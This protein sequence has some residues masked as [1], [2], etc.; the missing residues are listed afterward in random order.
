MTVSRHAHDSRSAVRSKLCKKPSAPKR[1]RR[2]CRASDAPDSRVCK[3][4][5]RTHTR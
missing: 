5:G 3:G 1:G 2:E 4:G